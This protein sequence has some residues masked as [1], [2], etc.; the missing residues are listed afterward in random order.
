MG[1]KKKAAGPPEKVHR[2]GI[3][4]DEARYL[5]YVDKQCNVVRMERGVARAKTEIVVSTGLKRERGFD[6]FVDADGDVA[7]EPE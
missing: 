4:K 6:Y 7:R 3:V 1:A 5:Y 2:A